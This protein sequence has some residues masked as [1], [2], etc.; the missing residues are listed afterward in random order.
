MLSI[1]LCYKTYP[2]TDSPPKANTWNLV[3]SHREIFVIPIPDSIPFDIFSQVALVLQ[4]TL[5][6]A[7]F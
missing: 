5:F 3:H 2:N 1:I 7:D 6:D 4:A